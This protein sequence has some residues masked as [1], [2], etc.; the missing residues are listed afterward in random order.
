MTSSPLELA[1]RALGEGRG[2]V[3]IRVIAAEGSTPREAGAAM[4]V[5]AEAAAGTIGGGRLEWEAAAEA[6]LMLRAGSKSRTMIVPLGP[7]IGQ[8]CG[9]RV[10]LRLEAGDAAKVAALE[11]E[12]QAT[13]E[14]RQTVLIH[15]AGHVGR[16]LALA[17]APLPFKVMLVDSRAEELGRLS[18][19]RIACLLTEKP[20]EAA[21][22][23]PP[24]AA[25]AVMT[26]SHALD[27]LI[28]AALLEESRFR[29]LGL[30][31]SATKKALFWRAFRDLGLPED[32]IARVRCPIGGSAVR[33]KRPEVIAALAAA[34]ITSALLGEDGGR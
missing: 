27:S 5:T 7:E 4:A 12:E 32:A 28:A 10:T 3:V 2:F 15:G 1:R 29:Y 8:C 13:R 23:A 21:A 9:G 19:P 34:E 33:D 16:A 26:H 22:A 17:L 18:E 11:N 24:G 25:H 30:I 31:G 20:V 14:R 6:R